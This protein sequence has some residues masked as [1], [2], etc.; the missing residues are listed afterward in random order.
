MTPSRP[1]SPTHTHRD[2]N[3]RRRRKGAAKLIDASRPHA[4]DIAWTAAGDTPAHYTMLFYGNCP[5]T[6][7]NKDK[8]ICVVHVG[9]I[10]I[11]RRWDRR[12]LVTNSNYRLKHATVVQEAQLSQ[13]DRSMLRVIEYSTHGISQ[14]LLNN[15]KQRVR[16][17]L[18]RPV[19]MTKY[20]L[21][22]IFFR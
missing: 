12:T 10:T 15:E 11:Q 17:L 1:T 20:S 3:Q 4:V 16:F 14:F 5:G 13:T 22:G 18:A 8:K 9:L 21:L 19:D 7:E 6:K 2:S